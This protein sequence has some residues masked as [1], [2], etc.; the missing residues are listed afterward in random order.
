MN[1]VVVMALAY[2]GP[3]EYIDAPVAAEGEVDSA[4]VGIT[5]LQ[6]IG[7]VLA[8]IGRAVSLE[9]ILIDP[10]AVEIEREHLT[11]IFFRPAI[12]LIDHQ[13]RMGVATAGGIGTRA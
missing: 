9:R 12:A 10:L 13:P 3:I 11:A 4:E 1:A 7:A 5:H 6:E 8:H 2:I